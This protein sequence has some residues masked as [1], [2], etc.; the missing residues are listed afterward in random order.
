MRVG[1]AALAE[2]VAQR[3]WASV[4]TVPL[5]TWRGGSVV[6]G[7]GED[8]KMLWVGVG[9]RG[10]SVPSVPAGGTLAGW[11]PSGLRI[12]RE[13]S[14]LHKDGTRLRAAGGLAES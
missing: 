7:G 4:P 8:H 10:A 11:L 12:E 13:V 14:A 1:R 9:K 2:A 6:V 5:M 3:T